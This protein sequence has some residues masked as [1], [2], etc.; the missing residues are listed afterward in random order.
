LLSVDE[1]P[2]GYCFQE[3][4]DVFPAGLQH[5]EWRGDDIFLEMT[6]CACFIDDGQGGTTE[7]DYIMP[8]RPKEE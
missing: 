7:I 1:D 5:A 4:A 2:G 8:L 6:R 3:C